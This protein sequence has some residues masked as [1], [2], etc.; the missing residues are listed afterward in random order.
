MPDFTKGSA[1][2]SLLAENSRVVDKARWSQL[3]DQTAKLLTGQP[4]IQRSR[5]VL[6]IQIVNSYYINSEGAEVIEPYSTARL[7]ISASVQADDGM[8]LN[9][10]RSVASSPSETRNRRTL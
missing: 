7:D 6:T 9:N 5:V 8:P 10:S 1:T 3:V 2:S 4:E